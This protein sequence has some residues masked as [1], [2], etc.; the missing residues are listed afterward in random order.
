MEMMLQRVMRQNVR[1]CSN[2]TRGMKENKIKDPNTT[3]RIRPMRIE[4]IPQVVELVRSHHFHFPASTLKFWHLQDRDG[5][6]IAVTESGFQIL[7][8]YSQ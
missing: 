8:S 7:S 5:M 1:L 3:F 2:F 4:D 6:R